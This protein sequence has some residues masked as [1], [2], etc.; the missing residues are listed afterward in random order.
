MLGTCLIARWLATLRTFLGIFLGLSFVFG[1]A[2]V[3]ALIAGGEITAGTVLVFFALLA[4]LLLAML[5]A[6]LITCLASPSTPAPPVPPLPGALTSEVDCGTAQQMLADA[7]AKAN[8]LEA[9]IN[10]QASRVASAQQTANIA[11]MTLAATGAALAASIFAP[12]TIPAAVSGFAAATYFVW[13]TAKNL[14]AE[15]TTL[16]RLASQLMQAQRDV[17]EA[18]MLVAQACSTHAPPTVPGGIGLT[19][20]SL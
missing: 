14:E 7:R 11:R 8:Q 10:A 16:A 3:I 9:E 1:I 4:L 6:D 17:T 15:L 2:I 18:E 19:T 12:W 13:R 20:G 5:I